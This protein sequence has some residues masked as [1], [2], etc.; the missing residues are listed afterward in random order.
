MVGLA[1]MHSRQACP[2]RARTVVKGAMKN[3]YVGDINDYRKYG[4]LRLLSGRGAL[5]TAVCWM[6]TEG[7]G[8][9][10]GE[11]TAYLNQPGKYR[12]YDPDLFDSL[13]RLVRADC[14]RDVGAVERAGIL[15]A[16]MFHSARL[17]DDPDERRQY[18]DAFFRAAAGCD[19]IFFDPDNGIEVKSVPPGRKDSAKYL[20]WGE[21]KRAFAAGA[22]VLIYQH[23]PRE[24]R[25]SYV[26]KLA[27]KILNRTGAGTAYAFSSAHVLFLLTVQ[28]THA[29]HFGE[30][31]E[32]V[33]LA[34]ECEF[35]VTIHSRPAPTVGGGAGRQ[36]GWPVGG[37]V[38]RTREEEA[39]AFPTSL[40]SGCGR[41]DGTRSGGAAMG[42]LPSALPATRRSGVRGVD[43]FP[44]GAVAEPR[45]RLL[46]EFQAL[47][48]G[49]PEWAWPYA[50][51]I[52][53]I[54]TEYA[55]GSGLLVYASAENLAWMYRKPI[56]DRFSSSRAWDR[57]RAVYEDEGRNSGD[58]FPIV[59]MAPVEDG[60]LLA[61]ALFIAGKLGLPTA[62]TPRA[63]LE[64]LAVTNW[65]KFVIQSKT[66]QDYV[67]DL[68]KLAESLPFVVA[69]LAALRPAV[70]L[71]PSSLW[72]RPALAGTMCQASP[73]TRYIDVPQ[74]NVT[75]VNCQA[76]MVDGHE[77]GQALRERLQA[78]PLGE[79]MRH[80]V[81]FREENA[82]RYIAWL[83]AELD[84]RGA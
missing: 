26:A 56:P 33:R 17:T 12:S 66:N 1:Q 58:F 71:V 69:E 43:D 50:P 70:A 51:S 68:A 48:T 54:G 84:A 3:Q 73:R 6:L 31:A 82:W 74:F 19:L 42:V 35:R 2:E 8:R 63:F 62:D 15:P 72:K 27:R 16:A 61:A 10:D 64:T 60:G 14:A 25:A 49:P 47:H 30:A 53:F 39:L 40:S 65:C 38:P 24:E 7:D 13:Q 59:G 52:P 5:S 23:F 78:T 36:S 55:V 79:W 18:M 44:A 22:S 75:V 80:L 9:G 28:E 37:S 45:A 11:K 81:E 34:W 20:Y 77:R 32:R 4:L 41:G 67:G 57:Y 46:S 21:L 76:S 29:T 83:D